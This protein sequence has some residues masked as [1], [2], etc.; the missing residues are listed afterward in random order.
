MVATQKP[1]NHHNPNEPEP[2][3]RSQTGKVYPPNLAEVTECRR[4]K[5]F[6]GESRCLSAENFLLFLH[7][8]HSLE[9]NNTAYAL[10]L[11]ILLA[12]IFCGCR[13]HRRIIAII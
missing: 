4:I 10:V 3:R 9:T 7:R 6:F 1:F 5:A 8:F 2:Y 12:T 11:Q 13:R